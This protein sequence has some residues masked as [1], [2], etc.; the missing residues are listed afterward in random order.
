M[1][2]F[3]RVLVPITWKNEGTEVI[4]KGNFPDFPS[5]KMQDV[6]SINSKSEK[7]TLLW[8]PPGKYFYSFI[9]DGTEKIDIDKPKETIKNK[10]YNVLKVTKETSNLEI[11]N[12]AKSQTSKSDT[13]NKVKKEQ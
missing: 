6:Y 10:V 1:N 2:N 12:E 4:L 3:D 9:V 8:L 7:S 13:G 11:I 5:I